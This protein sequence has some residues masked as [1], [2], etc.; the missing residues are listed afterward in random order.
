MNAFV[1]NLGDEIQDADEGLVS[2]S[3]PIDHHGDKV[4]IETFY[5]FSQS[6]S[7]RDLGMVDSKATE[8]DITIRDQDF[9]IKQSPGVLQSRRE[10]GTTGAAVWECSARFAE[11]LATS[12]NPLFRQDILGSGSAVLELG[13]GISGLV[14]LVLG[15]RIKTMVA[16]DQQYALSLLK[17]NIEANGD[18]GQKKRKLGPPAADIETLALD[19]E[20]DDFASTFRAH[21][22]TGVFDAVVACDCVFNYALINPFVEACVEACR[23]K[24]QTKDGGEDPTEPAICVVAQQLRQPDVYQQWLETF[25]KTFQV[26]RVS[27]DMLTENLKEGSGFVVHIGMLR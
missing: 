14:P 16:S 26:W 2:F 3:S 11:W 21:G 4:G 5:L 23:Y 27:D 9:V 19:W 15:P 10:G 13:A 20:T 24:R 25:L 12:I 18:R 7:S 6:H 8:L 17:E 22:L 1:K